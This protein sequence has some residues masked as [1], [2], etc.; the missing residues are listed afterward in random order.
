MVIRVGAASHSFG[1]HMHG[2]DALKYDSVL[3]NFISSQSYHC[4]HL[5]GGWPGHGPC[6]HPMLPHAAPDLYSQQCFCC[7]SRHARLFKADNTLL[8]LRLCV[9]LVLMVVDLF[10]LCNVCPDELTAASVRG[11]K[12]V[13]QRNATHHSDAQINLPQSGM[14]SANWPPAWHATY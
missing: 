2:A 7:A 6:T 11:S 1:T 3:H 12:E 13:F 8:V 9:L 5:L 10:Q 4:V 14:C